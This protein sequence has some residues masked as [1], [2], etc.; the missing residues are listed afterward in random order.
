MAKKSKINPLYI[1]AAVLVG[2]YFLLGKSS[3]TAARPI[4][5]P[6]AGMNATQYA[7]LVSSGI[8]TGLTTAQAI[9]AAIQKMGGAPA[10]ATAPLANPTT[11]SGGTVPSGGTDNADGT[12]TD[13]TGEVW[14]QD[15]TTG[16]W[17]DT[18]YNIINGT[19]NSGNDQTGGSYITQNGILV[20]N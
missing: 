20:G 15:A 11:A 3:S 17:D 4:P 19:Y 14:Q 5:S 12:Y 10:A 18:G 8:S 2:G 9:Q 1:G 6:P 7:S 16:T 13:P